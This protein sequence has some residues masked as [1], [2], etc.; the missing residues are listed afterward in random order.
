M[1]PI[2]HVYYSKNNTIELTDLPQKGLIKFK[3]FSKATKLPNIK[4]KVYSL[5]EYNMC[6]S[7]DII[8]R[9]QLIPENELCVLTNTS[10]NSFYLLDHEQK[11]TN[12]SE[13]LNTIEKN[14]KNDNIYV[15]MLKQADIFNDYHESIYILPLDIFRYN[16]NHGLM[17]YI[18]ETEIGFDLTDYS[19]VFQG[20]DETYNINIEDKIY[21]AI[22]VEQ[23]KLHFIEDIMSLPFANNIKLQIKNNFI[24]TIDYQTYKEIISNYSFNKKVFDQ[25][26][27]KNITDKQR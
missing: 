17:D 27:T 22:N 1:K 9:L 5:I 8:N 14:L 21:K 13:F 25:I 11:I 18:N 6:L 4:N 12:T 26:K 10:N 3:K 16:H 20:Y 15:C 23:I 24:A 7:K 19:L 2:K